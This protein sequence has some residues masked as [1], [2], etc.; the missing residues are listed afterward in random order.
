MSGGFGVLA[1]AIAIVSHAAIVAVGVE[2]CAQIEKLR[3][4]LGS[5]PCSSSRI[6]WTRTGRRSS[7]DNNAASKATSSLPLVP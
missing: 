1:G 6:H 2:R 4:P 5:Q 7:R 3:R